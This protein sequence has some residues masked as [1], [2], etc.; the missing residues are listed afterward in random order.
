LKCGGAHAKFEDVVA[1]FPAKVRGQKVA[2]FPH[3]AW[4]L[5]E[6]MRM[7][8]WDILEF[9]RDRKH[10]SPDWPS[11]YWPGE[12]PGNATAWAEHQKLKHCAMQSLVANPKTDLI[13]PTPWAM[14]KQCSAKHCSLRTTM[15]ITWGSWSH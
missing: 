10:V 3:T 14:D 5:L 11:G 7:A 6:H 2:N 4:M 1:D 8:Q 13:R 15:P 9:S 12:A